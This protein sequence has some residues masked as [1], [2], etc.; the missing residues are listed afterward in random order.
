MIYLKLMGFAL[1]PTAALLAGEFEPA[2]SATNQLGLDLYQQF[3]IDRPGQNLLLSPFSIQSALALAYSGADGTTRTEMT[4]V[5]HFP[6][7][8]TLLQSSFGALY[9]ALNETAKKSVLHAVEIKTE[10]K[11]SV[12]IIEWHLANRIFGQTGCP[13]RDSFLALMRD[14]YRAPLEQLDFRGDAELSRTKINDWV[15]EQTKT[16]IHELIR[17]AASTTKRGSFS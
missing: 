4:R 12:E 2:A 17:Q 5:L 15:E 8:D 9:A 1:L 10:E 16:K 6:M 13:F 7:Q 3:A 14:G 11:G